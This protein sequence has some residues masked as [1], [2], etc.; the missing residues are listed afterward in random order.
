MMQETK[1]N[2][3]L[4]AIIF[5]IVAL[6]P[7]LACIFW[8]MYEPYPWEPDSSAFYFFRSKP[9]GK[10]EH[11]ATLVKYTIDSGEQVVL[12]GSGTIPRARAE[13]IGAAR[14]LPVSG[15]FVWLQKG[16]SPA[17]ARVENEQSAEQMCL[18]SFSLKEKAIKHNFML[19]RF[20]DG[21]E[22]P[23]AFSPTEDALYYV[24]DGYPGDEDKG[25]FLLKLDIASGQITP[26]KMPLEELEGGIQISEN[27]DAMY[28]AAEDCILLYDFAEKTMPVVWSGSSDDGTFSVDGNYMK[29]GNGIFKK[30]PDGIGFSKNPI[31]A[32][33]APGDTHLT[34]DIVQ[35]MIVDRDEDILSVVDIPARQAV[36]ILWMPF[37]D[38]SVIF[39]LS[40]S[41]NKAYS[42]FSL[43]GA[44]GGDE[45]LVAV[46]ETESKIVKDIVIPYEEGTGEYQQSFAARALAF[47]WMRSPGSLDLMKKALAWEKLQ[48]DTE[49]TI[50]LRNSM[51]ASLSEKD[52]R[53]LKDLLTEEEMGSINSRPTIKNTL[54]AI[55]KG[56][57]AVID[58]FMQSSMYH[59]D[60]DKARKVF[61]KLAFHP[62]T[63]K[64]EV[65]E[66]HTRFRKLRSLADIRERNRRVERR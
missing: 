29:V 3:R 10:S 35:N 62:D 21:G 1:R 59:S 50:K 20:D 48:E 5:G 53:R 42:V 44:L 12:A 22:T 65:I 24:V 61:E 47:Q 45:W 15:D 8:P 23:F 34:N 11:Q 27:G 51:V 64:E 36:P 14:F 63:S 38:D 49:E 17:M 56:D 31:L 60:L 66:L 9:P 55:E 28:L 41:P 46:V 7:S 58:A 18:V 33:T 37:N 54:K 39:G 25:I 6:L 26:T 57:R 16:P 30:E 2:Y 19:P 13:T 4:G 40:F 52:A 32:L 43:G